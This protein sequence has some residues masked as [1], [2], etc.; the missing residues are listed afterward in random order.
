MN[1]SRI[2]NLV[3]LNEL[4][5]E[6]GCSSALLSAKDMAYDLAIE[7]HAKQQIASIYSIY[8]ELHAEELNSSKV[9]S[10]IEGFIVELQSDDVKQKFISYLYPSLKISSN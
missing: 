7:N 6:Q 3:K 10:A 1:L 8:N 2:I 9:I 5:T 4:I